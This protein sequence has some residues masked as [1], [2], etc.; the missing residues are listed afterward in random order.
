[1]IIVVTLVSAALV[2][3]RVVLAAGSRLAG[4]LPR[5]GH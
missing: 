5:L 3:V 1:L 4:G 2:T